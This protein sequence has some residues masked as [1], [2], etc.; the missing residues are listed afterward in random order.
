MKF[1]TNE[2]YVEERVWDKEKG[3][4]KNSKASLSVH[5]EPLK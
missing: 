1:T 2:E 4:V 5:W 3:L